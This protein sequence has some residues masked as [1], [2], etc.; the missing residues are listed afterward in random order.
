MKGNVTFGIFKQQLDFLKLGPL[1]SYG[2]LGFG[3]KI[4]NEQKELGEK[5][6]AK[7]RAI[8][9]SMTKEE[10]N[11]G[12][13]FLTHSRMTR[14]SKGSGTK[15]EDIKELSSHIKKMKKMFRGMDSKKMEGLAKQFEGKDPEN[16]DMSKVD[17]SQF[18]NMKGM[19]KKKLRFK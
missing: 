5:K 2:F 3:N 1:A 8:L 4:T 17:M 7:Y 9:S 18:A 10:L 19:K 11:N 13:D 6:M 12:P 16:I 14:I 15:I